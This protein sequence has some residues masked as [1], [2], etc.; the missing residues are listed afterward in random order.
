MKGFT[1][2][3]AGLIALALSGCAFTPAAEISGDPG[4]PAAA[5]GAFTPVPQPMSLLGE[6]ARSQHDHSQH[7]HSQHDHSQHDHS[8]HDHSQHDHS[9][10]DHS[11]HDHSQHG[12]DS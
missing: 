6:Q 4:H 7:D 10:H 8:Q 5:Q 9:Q 1:T 12:G 2:V 3:V 11:Q